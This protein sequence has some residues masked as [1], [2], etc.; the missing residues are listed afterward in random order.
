MNI[1]REQPP[2]HPIKEVEMITNRNSKSLAILLVL[3]VALVSVSFVTR[4]A[5]AIITGNLSKK[6]AG[7]SNVIS[8]TYLPLA[9]GKQT[10]LY[11]ASKPAKGAGNLY[12]RD[13]NW[14]PAAGMCLCPACSA[15]ESRILAP[16]ASAGVANQTYVVSTNR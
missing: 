2:G 8:N 11:N 4:P 5:N 1:D 16:H 15:G 14:R 7:F 6:E 3:A 12:H 10:Q 13:V 9:P